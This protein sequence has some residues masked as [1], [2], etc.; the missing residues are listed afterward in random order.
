[1]IEKIIKH[2]GSA[3]ALAKELGVTESAVS[4]WWDKGIPPARAIEIEQLTNGEIKAI[5]IVMEVTNGS[6]TIEG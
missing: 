3:K 4:Q 2:F 5:D 1:M 6:N